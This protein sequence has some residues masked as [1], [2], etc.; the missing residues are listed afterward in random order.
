MLLQ[1]RKLVSGY[2]PIKVLKSVSIDVEEGQCVSIIGANGAG[3]TTLLRNIFGLLKA[4]SGQIIFKGKD[5]TNLLTNN[6]VKLGLIH[7]P[8]GR[9]IFGPL[10]I[11]ENLVIGCI[12][13]QRGPRLEEMFQYVWELFPVLKERQHQR[14]DT[15]S[16]GEQQ[17]LSLARGLMGQPQLLVMDE[18]SVGLDPLRVAAL[19]KALEQ[20]KQI[21]SILLVEQNARLALSLSEKVYIIKNGEIVFQGT[22]IELRAIPE[23]I[24]LYFG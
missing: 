12:K 19:L 3:K 13:P 16:G 7:I 5:I 21:A 18:P 6:R 24:E 20:I 22:P 17:M 2:G 15:L 1:V 14:G 10:T 4:E 23:L 9:R 11:Y 8:E